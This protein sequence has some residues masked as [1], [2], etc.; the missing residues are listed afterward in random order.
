MSD[1]LQPQNRYTALIV[2]DDPAIALLTEALVEEHGYD[3]TICS[4]A[5]RAWENFVENQPHLLLIDWML[6]GMN[7][8]E[9]CEKLKA[10]ERGKYLTILMI[11][12]KNDPEDMAKAVNAGVNFFMAKPIKKEILDVWL[13]SA[14]KHID[15][16]L[17]REVDDLALISQ[18]QALEDFND[19]LEDSI[20]R[21]NQMAAEAERAYIE[22]SQIFKTVAG[23]I[24]LIDTDF[25]LLRCNDSFLEMANVSWEESQSC[26]CYE[27][28]RSSLCNTEKCPL[29]RIKKEPQRIEG[30]IERVQ[31]NGESLFYHIVTTPF[32]GLAGDLIGIVEHISDVTDRVKA[33]QALKQ[34]ELRYKKLSII[35]ELTQLYNKR[36]FNNELPLE[37]E[38]ARRYKHPLSLLLLDIDNFKHHND[39]YGHADGDK[40]LER[41][42]K[43]V[44][45][46]LRVNDVPCRYGGEEFTIILP[47]T[48]GENALV[49]AERIRENFAA[50]GFYPNPGE[51]VQ[52]TV[53]VG[54]T[55]YVAGEEAESL[56]ERADGNMYQAKQS[57][58][59]KCVFK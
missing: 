51:K 20:G 27:V 15:D 33:E 10:T 47:D 59:N 12:G 5:E 22:I 17:R 54:V 1:C 57:G 49:V 52:K 16:C 2:E 36:Y 30:E 26:K 32:K 21:A 42:G 4:D 41:L 44:V 40:V 55:Q 39:T 37:V 24:L 53:S 48:S 58:K 6:P 14:S 45:S 19:Q 46:A 9:F 29:Q 43:V 13:S 18:K 50:E 11:T 31:A 56:L 28:F 25:N 38:R 34:S 7:G 35:D 23:G 8:V 3:V